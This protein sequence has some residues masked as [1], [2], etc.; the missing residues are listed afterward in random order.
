[1]S[2]KPILQRGAI[3]KNITLISKLK[4]IRTLAILLLLCTTFFTQ[5][6]VV[7]IPDQNFLE[8]LILV[9]A[10]ANENGFIEVSEV[11]KWEE[12]GIGYKQIRSLKGI[13]AFKSL[14]ILKGSA[15]WISDSVDLSGL[16]HLEY[17]DL[18]S[19]RIEAINVG[20]L[21]KLEYINLSANRIASI[22]LDAFENLEFLNLGSTGLTSL[23]VGGFRKLDS[24]KISYTNITELDL[25]TNVNLKM[26]NAQR[27]QLS[28]LSLVGLPELIYVNIEDNASLTSLDLVDLPKLDEI[29][30]ENSRISDL[31]I[32]DLPQL[33]L[34]N[35]R[36]NDLNQIDLLLYPN[37]EDIDLEYNTNLSVVQVKDLPNLQILK[38][39]GC[40]IE[41]L[42][43]SN[44]ISLRHLGLTGNPLKSINLEGLN[45]IE[46]LNLRNLELESLSVLDLPLLTK[47][48]A[49]Y[50]KILSASIQNCPLLHVIRLDDNEMNQFE[51]LNLPAL[52]QL[53]INGN[54]LTTYTL[55]GFPSL[56]T[57]DIFN[58]ELT[59]LDLNSLP[60][61]ET[62][63]TQ[64]NEI[65]ELNLVD[66]PALITVDMSENKMTDYVLQSLPGLLSFNLSFNELENITLIDL[67]NLTSLD[68]EG[69]LLSQIDFFEFAS[70]TLIDLSGNLFVEMDF[71]EKPEDLNVHVKLDDNLLLDYLNIQNGLED[72]GNYSL[73]NTPLL[74]FVCIDEE[75][76]DL[77]GAALFLAANNAALG[78]DCDYIETIPYFLVGEARIDYD[79]NGCTED[80]PTFAGLKLFIENETEE[81]CLLNNQHGYYGKFLK[82]PIQN[83]TATVDENFFSVDPT[84]IQIDLSNF[85]T[86]TVEQDFCVSTI[87]DF[88]DIEIVMFPT[89]RSRPGFEATYK[90]KIKNN[91]N[92]PAS[93]QITI[94]YEDKLIDFIETDGQINGQG[95]G[96]LILDYEE[97]GPQAFQNIYTTFRLNTPTD[98]CPLNAGDILKFEVTAETSIVDNDL[99]NNSF[100]LKVAVVNSF[101]PNDKICMEGDVIKP[102]QLDDFL[103]YMIRFENTGNA[104]AVNVRVQDVLSTTTYDASTLEIIEA[105]HTMRTEITNDFIV[106]FIFDEIDLPFDDENN[107]GYVVFKVKPLLALEPW[108][109]IRN[110]ASIFFDFNAPIITNSA[111]TIILRDDDNDGYYEDVDCD[112]YNVDV[113]PL[114]LEVIYN[115]IDD[116]CDPLTLDDDLDGDGFALEED[117]D[118]ENAMINP[119]MEEEAYNGIDD[120]C[121]PLTLDDDLDGD[122]FALGE[123]CDDE[124]ANINPDAMDIPDNGIDEDCDGIDAT[125]FVD[126]DGDGFT[127]EVDC[128]DTNPA[129]HPD[130]IEVCNNIDD[131]CDG[132]VD[133]GLEVFTYYADADGDGYGDLATAEDACK[134]PGGYVVNGD[135]CDDTN[136][137]VNPDAEEIPNNGIDEDCDGED[138]MTSMRAFEN[139]LITV[140]PNPAKESIWVEKIGDNLNSVSIYNVAGQLIKSSRNVGAQIKLDISSLEQGIY[141]LEVND[142]SEVEIFR[143]MKM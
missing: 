72:G 5:A 87:F 3:A 27:S 78:V 126:S 140:Y 60:A 137:T 39:S 24:L 37:L 100:T 18:A 124:N 42:D 30:A 119:S 36:R 89:G 26:L 43:V 92:I 14:R 54:K 114:T 2:K 1:M 141:F 129:V 45:S 139:S 136:P 47:I 53:Y 68:L 17:V 50:N 95:S 33:R 25:S 63:K 40:E 127:N 41:S 4:T 64:R 85:E 7:D 116:D 115:G 44:C 15:N 112:D 82:D 88:T 34:F 51:I 118:D 76:R 133:E 97:L 130:A 122:G 103:H 56:K 21:E 22:E 9:G 110:E 86:A 98:E 84:E 99:T 121:D 28:S 80:D 75:D 125:N 131:N 38:L 134:Q 73:I 46:D 123:D 135:D 62:L 61:L 142:G 107:D 74:R 83:I 104:S 96:S 20:G 143:F 59:V 69:N 109:I 11:D 55:R 66:L 79:K 120:D 67:P 128:D 77:M 81:V 31:Q 91:G 71:S 52:E 6:Q 65:Q 13:E 117:C 101:D 12:L 49:R 108:N 106:N 19:N 138:L 10:D 90:I 23:D 57:L 105:S 35:F 32:Q 8:A 29:N 113:N 93:G 102:D 132:S 58:N 16:I 48:D 111:E 70:L 94:L